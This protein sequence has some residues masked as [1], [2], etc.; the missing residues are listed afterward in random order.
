[1]I[2]KGSSG[3]ESLPEE[4]RDYAD[5]FDHAKADTLPVRRRFNH[6]IPLEE[7]K[8]PPYGPLYSLSAKELLET[9]NYLDEHLLNGF[10]QPSQSPAAAPILFVKKKDGSLCLCV[11]YQGLNRITIKNQYP[12]PLI[13]EL[14]DCLS[15][16]W[17]FSKID[18]CNAYHQIHI[19]EGD[20]WKMAFRTRYRLFEYRVMPF[21]L[22]NTPTSFQSL[23][24][25]TLSNMIDL[26]VIACLDDI[27]FYSDTR[28]EHTIHSPSQSVTMLMRKQA[29]HQGLKMRVLLRPY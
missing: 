6:H 18:L 29:V 28:E 27:L 2:E 17:Y 12:L 24:N 26:F 10:I 1:L 25:S 9:R 4:N 7:G 22:T 19:A 13:P 20:E 8:A 14:L 21:S 11:D 5:M 23:V 16:A 15:T 3:S